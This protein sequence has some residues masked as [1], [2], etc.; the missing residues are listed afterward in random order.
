MALTLR[1]RFNISR[2]LAG[3]KA[4]SDTITLS[5][6][7]IFIIPNRQGLAFS[8]LVGLTLL[9]SVVYDNNLGFILTFLLFSLFFVS[10]L[11][12]FRNLS[13]L[14]VQAGKCESVFAGEQ[15]V[16]RLHIE[17]CS[18]IA[19][20]QLNIQLKASEEP[21]QR[22]NIAPQATAEL[23]VPIKTYRR[24]WHEIGT[25]RLFTLFPLGLLYAWS[26]LR[27]ER[28]ILVYPKPTDNS[29]PWPYSS[30][31]SSN[32]AGQQQRGQ[33]DFYGF[34]QYQP[35]DPLKQVYW[36]AVAKGLG[37]HTKQYSGAYGSVSELWFDWHDSGAGGTERRLSQLCR[38]IIEAEQQEVRYG[39]RMPNQTIPINHGPVHYDRCLTALALFAL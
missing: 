27:L 13:G 9:A 35:G 29:E 22:I 14:I 36:K 3:E 31:D 2:F 16:F 10:I 24:G 1:D 4:D 5:H 39:L 32:P 38:W 11:H 34:R 12:S 15:T 33:D 19:R 23:K 28:R 20:I 7:R 18:N 25:I 6:R 30:V 21:P 8:V 17:N 26:P 37:V